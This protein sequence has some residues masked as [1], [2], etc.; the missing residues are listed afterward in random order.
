MQGLHICHGVYFGGQRLIAFSG[1]EFLV[2]EDLSEFPKV[3]S[4]LS[5]SLTI[6]D[7][8]C[9]F[10]DISVQNRVKS[11]TLLLL[12]LLLNHL[13][14]CMYTCTSIISGMHVELGGQLTGVSFPFYHVGPG[15]WIQAWW[16]VPLPMESSHRPYLFS[17][18]V[19][20]SNQEHSH[21]KKMFHHRETSP[22]ICF[23]LFSKNFHSV[24]VA[25]LLNIK[26]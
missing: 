17:P 16:R 8:Q 9:L 25:L 14:D 19:L 26:N 1:S 13:L 22:T 2:C 4:K 23:F 3:G 5:R 20:R 15:N 11:W 24:F 10:H 18:L 6:F 12:L 21:S 7:H